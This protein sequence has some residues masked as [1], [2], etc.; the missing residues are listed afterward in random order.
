MLDTVIFAILDAV[1][2]YA[3]ASYLFSAFSPLKRMAF[4][5][6]HIFALILCIV[7][8]LFSVPTPVAA[9]SVFIT[10]LIVSVPYK[11]KWYNNI[12]ISLFFLALS[13]ASEIIVGVT[14]ME[15]FS[16]SFDNT[17]TG[18]PFFIGLILSRFVTYIITY[19]VKISNH[20]LFHKKFNIKWLLLFVLPIA[21]TLVCMLM[22]KNIQDGQSDQNDFGV[23]VI[24]TLL[25]LSNIFVFY[26]IDDMYDTILNKEKLNLAQELIRQQEKQYAELY[27]SSI[28]IRKLRHNYKNF[29]LGALAE[30]N[31]GNT[32]SVKNAFDEE[33]KMLSAPAL[34]LSG[35]SAFDAFLNYKISEAEKDGIKF[36]FSFRNM[37][38]VDFSNLDLAVLLGN[39]IDNAVEATKASANKDKVITLSAGVNNL[40]LIV[41]IVNPTDKQIDTKNLNTDKKD[42]YNHGFGIVSMKQIVQKHDGEIIFNFCD[43]NFE[44]IIYLPFSSRISE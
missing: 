2:S 36:D 13:F 41:S 8:D 5:P 37:K 4:S 22:Y 12:F 9:A 28:E 18:L 23:L 25:C 1:L 21:T 31:Q 29:L 24:L 26:F 16:M 38:D 11:L 35:N 30:I 33:L 39:A 43:G 15:I 19:A 7:C 32:E 42:V 14:M 34:V 3:A 40:Q 27:E 6:F 17:V 10:A 20:K 44:T